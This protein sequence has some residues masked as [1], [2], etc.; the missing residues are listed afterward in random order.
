MNKTHSIR[1]IID[2]GEIF[3]VANNTTSKERSYRRTIW[4]FQ[5]YYNGDWC[6][7]NDDMNV[8]GDIDNENV[9][10]Y[11]VHKL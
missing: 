7:N 10:L 11:R 9:I 8:L 5:G 1:D 6:N 2:I 3:I 4:G